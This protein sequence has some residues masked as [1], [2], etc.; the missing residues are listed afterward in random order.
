MLRAD[1]QLPP[2]LQA[3]RTALLAAEPAIGQAQVLTAEFCRL[4]RER[5]AAAFPSWLQGAQHSGLPEMREFARV[6]E[7]DRAAVENV[8]RYEWSNGVT[9]GHVNKLKL[10]KRSMYGRAN[11]DLLRRRVLHAA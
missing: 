4:V 1:G 10:I 11:F 8:L 2:D 6:L 9:E 3:Y 7:R 5:D